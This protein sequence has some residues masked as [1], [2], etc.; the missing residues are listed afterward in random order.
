M[1][2]LSPLRR[3]RSLF[4]GQ[5]VKKVADKLN[6]NTVSA[7]LIVMNAALL[8]AFGIALG[9]GDETHIPKVYLA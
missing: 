5:M 7:V 4:E 8:A 9:E 6:G 3:R 1:I 2:T